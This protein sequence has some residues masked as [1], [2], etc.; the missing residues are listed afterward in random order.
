MQCSILDRILEQKK[1]QQ[2]KNWGDSYK[3][4]GLVHVNFVILINVP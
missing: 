1:G 3:V 4:C 2:K